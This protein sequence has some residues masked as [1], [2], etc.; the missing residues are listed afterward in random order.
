M[1]VC[2]KLG[3]DSEIVNWKGAMHGGEIVVRLFEE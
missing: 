2:C 1:C 3:K